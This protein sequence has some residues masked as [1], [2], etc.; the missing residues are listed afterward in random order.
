MNR[1][2][3]PFSITAILLASS[4]L[5]EA[6]A[7]QALDKVPETLRACV[8]EEDDALRLACYD[9]EVAKLG[10]MPADAPSVAAAQ[11]PQRTEEEAFG[12]PPLKLDPNE[13]L[14]EITA[15][16]TKIQKGAGIVTVWLDNSQIWQQKYSGSFLIREGDKVTVKKKSLGGYRLENRGR[17]IDV[18]RVK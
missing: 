15:T 17:R 10:S 18:K 8:E 3:I 5:P 14:M 2:S 1:F 9:R 6:W 13:Q 7:E 4:G 12:Q 16:V 11:V